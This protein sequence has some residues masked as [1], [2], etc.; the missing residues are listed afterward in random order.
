MRQLFCAACLLGASL[1]AAEEASYLMRG[2]QLPAAVVSNGY[3]QSVSPLPSGELLVRVTTLL[4]PIGST[5]SYGALRAGSAVAVPEGFALPAG[6]RRE[7]RDDLD[8]WEAATRILEW[9]SETVR[10]EVD[11]DGPQDAIAVLRRQQGRCSGLAN[12]AAALLLA[13]GFEA[14][15]VSGLLVTSS[16]AIPHRWVECRLP[17]AGWVPTDPTLGLWVITPGHVAFPDAVRS[18]PT[19]RVLRARDGNLGRL[20]RVNGRPLRPNLGSE[21]VC[22]LVGGAEGLRAVAALYGR[23]GDV[24]RSVLNPDG[25]FSG[26]LPGRWRLVVVA[27]GRVLE[28]R[29]LELKSGELHSF[30]VVA[31]RPA[32]DREVGS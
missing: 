29:E 9:V 12:A 19:I 31:P 26:L 24:R 14:R 22:S 8:A 25:R 28:D 32:D 16:G 5:G 6:I 3:L 27:E 1:A 4:A 30:P 11:D 21:L 20:P 18:L 13:A 2:S 7:L 15:T 23:D 17:G 10:L